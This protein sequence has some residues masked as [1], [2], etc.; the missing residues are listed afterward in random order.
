MRGKAILVLSLSGQYHEYPLFAALTRDI[1]DI[2]PQ[3]IKLIS[4]RPLCRN[5]TIINA[6]R[7]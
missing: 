5:L 3:A 4:P 1:Y 7:H 6:Y 2:V